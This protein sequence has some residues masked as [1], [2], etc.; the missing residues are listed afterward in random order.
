[1]VNI[2]NNM[3]VSWSTPKRQ[4]T[5]VQANI[6]FYRWEHLGTVVWA[7]V[8]IKSISLE[9]PIS[10]INFKWYIS[11]KRVVCFDK[12]VQS[13]NSWWEWCQN[14]RQIVWHGEVKIFSQ[15]IRFPVN[16]GLPFWSII[17]CCPGRFVLYVFVP[18][19]FCQDCGLD[20]GKYQLHLEW[21]IQTLAGKN[22]TDSF[23][24]DTMT[25]PILTPSEFEHLWSHLLCKDAT[26]SFEHLHLFPA[27]CSSAFTFSMLLT[28]PFWECQ[29]ICFCLT[30]LVSRRQLVLS[31][32]VC[33]WHVMLST[34]PPSKKFAGRSTSTSKKFWFS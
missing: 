31:A 21:N 24:V 12:N 27:V 11:W 5:K 22:N 23:R 20:I 15:V 30:L 19:F 2:Y 1:M 17:V 25:Q 14:L 6:K 18:F 16:K 9:K 26:P 32:C 29:R 8:D 7:V 28:T 33:L 4:G 3:V 34:P 13:W 10:P